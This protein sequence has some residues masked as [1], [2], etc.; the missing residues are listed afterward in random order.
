VVTQPLACAVE[1]PDPEVPKLRYALEELLRGL[2]LRPAWTPPEHAALYAGARPEHAPE[3]ALR[4]RL[5]DE[6]WGALD[7]P[8]VARP[9]A[10]GWIEHDGRRTPLP[11]GPGGTPAAD[12]RAVVEADVLGSAFWWLTGGQEGATVER[13]AHGRF[14]YARSLQAD[15][16]GEPTAPV[17]ALRLWLGDALRATGARVPGR[18]W[19]GAPWAVALSHDLDAVRTPRLRALAAGLVTGRPR[20]AL[21]RAFGPDP[22][23]A[24]VD[25]LVALARRHGTRSTL[26]VKTVGPGSPEDVPYRIDGALGAHLRAL[27]ADGFEVGLHPGYASHDHPG[28]LAAE[29]G[30]LAAALGVAPTSA[31]S[32][33]L[34]WSEPTTPRLYARAGFRVDSTLGFAEAVGFRRG[35]SHPFRLWDPAADAPT[36]LWEMPLAA[37]DTTLFTH[38]GLSDEAAAYR[39][40]A[41]LAEARR[42]GGG[43]VVLWHPA[44]DGDPAW[45]RR[46]DVLDHAVGQAARD[47]AAVGPLGALLGAWA[48]QDSP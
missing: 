26:F 5:G 3:H 30:R 21:T 41:V 47:G 13:D 37:M 42:A 24:S 17:D 8:A 36:D 4:L 39:L 40:A 22:R 20:R 10:L 9:D 18:T 48:G 16:G 33:F 12:A 19:G 38:L 46:L 25:A 14:P 43:A 27:T 32:H 44:M 1:G 29:R 34:R 28:R 31:R 11:V 45:A 2:G 15:L 23:R 35:T 7:R 6:T